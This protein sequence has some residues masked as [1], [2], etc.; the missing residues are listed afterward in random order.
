MSP[1]LPRT[2][3]PSG[4]RR[5]LLAALVLLSGV[6]GECRWRASSNTSGRDR[7]PPQS[8]DS[9]PLTLGGRSESVLPVPGGRALLYSRT[10][11]AD[12]I[13]EIRWLDLETGI[14]VALLHGQSRPWLERIDGDRFEYVDGGCE[15]VHLVCR[16]GEDSPSVLDPSDVSA[17]G[18][19]AQRRLHVIRSSILRW[20]EGD[21]TVEV[22]L[23]FRAAGAVYEPGWPAPLA[24]DYRGD[25]RWVDLASGAGA[26]ALPFRPLRRT[27]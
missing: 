3:S 20:S 11:G 2:P 17:R 25:L 22:P 9:P 18:P 16:F 5:A 19:A 23:A 10:P 14:S 24:W 6:A 15:L 8:N 13:A 4:A 21:V 26:P 1:S 27:P 12:C 7:R